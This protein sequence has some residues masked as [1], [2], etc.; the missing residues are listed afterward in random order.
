MTRAGIRKRLRILHDTDGLSFPKIAARREFDPI[1]PSTLNSIY[2]GG[3]IPKKWQEQ[4]RYPPPRPP[5]IAIRLD[6]PESAAMS[7]QNNMEPEV[8]AEL[9]ELLEVE[10]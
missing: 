3:K 5:R 9:I 7:I 6:N 10:K 4:L 1:P 2:H 8:M